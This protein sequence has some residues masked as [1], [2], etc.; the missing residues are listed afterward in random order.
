MRTT[1][2]GL[3]APAENADNNEDTSDVT[4]ERWQC[5]VCYAWNGDIPT[6]RSSS[7]HAASCQTCGRPKHAPWLSL[8]KHESQVRYAVVTVSEIEHTRSLAQSQHGCAYVVLQQIRLGSML[9]LTPANGAGAGATLENGAK[10]VAVV[11]GIDYTTKTLQLVSAT[12]VLTESADATS[13]YASTSEHYK[14]RFQELELQYPLDFARLAPLAT[15]TASSVD[16]GR[17]LHQ[18][19]VCGTCRRIFRACQGERQSEDATAELLRSLAAELDALRTRKQLQIR[20]RQYTLVLDTT[21]EIRT[22]ERHL[23][24]AKRQ[25]EFLEPLSCPFCGWV[26]VVCSPSP[27]PA[28]RQEQHQD[29]GK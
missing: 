29:G 5:H 20:S 1:F 11:V 12:P 10:V 4:P 23:R 15:D 25:L 7:E 21:A 2:S 24:L 27:S 9:D 22:T 3:L 28:S 14:L 26:D 18:Y 13:A 17:S 6:H 8:E 19:G 16:W